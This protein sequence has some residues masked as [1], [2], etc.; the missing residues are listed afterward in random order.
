LTHFRALL[1]QGKN[2]SRKVVTQRTAYIKRR[3]YP[4]SSR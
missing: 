2:R 3:T 1:R 4:C